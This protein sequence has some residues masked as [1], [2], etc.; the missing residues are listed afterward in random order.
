LAQNAMFVSQ[1]TLD[2]WLTEE[3]VAVEGDV[4][5]LMPE[6]QR[7]TLTSAV[8]FVAEVADGGDE[9]ELVGRV[10]ALD[11]LAAFGGEHY[12]DSVILDDNAY[13]V[14]EG[15]LGT[16]LGREA[17]SERPAHDLAAATRLA[18]G[19]DRPPSAELDLLARFFLAEH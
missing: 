10:K 2:G 8:H 4:M 13:E 5:T 11:V 6:G 14:V 12:A 18:V 3:R 1:E 19:E 15:F 16:S 17:H 9:K 7:F